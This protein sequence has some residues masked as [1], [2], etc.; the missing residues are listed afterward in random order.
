[1]SVVVVI[2]LCVLNV[3]FCLYFFQHVFTQSH[4]VRAQ[5]LRACS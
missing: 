4:S 1:M 3:E 5:T 2:S